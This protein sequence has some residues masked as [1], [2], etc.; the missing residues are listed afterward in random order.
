MKQSPKEA[1]RLS[2]IQESTHT[3]WSQK[4][5]PTTFTSAHHQFVSWARSIQSIPPIPLHEGPTY[6][7]P[8]IYA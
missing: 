1:N 6:Y 7:Y 8:H 2:A 3:L 4:V 5:P